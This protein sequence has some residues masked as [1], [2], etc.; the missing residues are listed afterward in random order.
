M[1]AS[2]KIAGAGRGGAGRVGNSRSTRFDDGPSGPFAL[3]MSTVSTCTVAGCDGPS[4]VVGA[5][6][7][8]DCSTTSGG[9]LGGV[10]PPSARACDVLA[11]TTPNP[12]AATDHRP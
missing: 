9:R 1:L 12:T 5:I 4:F 2:T 10:E 7:G 8:I 6:A 11:S 3:E